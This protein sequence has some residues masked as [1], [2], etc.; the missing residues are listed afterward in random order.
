MAGSIVGHVL[1]VETEVMAQLVDDRVAD[2]A[3]DLPA[4]RAGAQDRPSVDE[5][6][7]GHGRLIEAVALRQGDAL[8]EA[9]QLLVRL[10]AEGLQVFRIGL[11]L[12]H[13][14]HVLQQLGE[15]LGQ[16]FQGLLDQSLELLG[17][18]AHGA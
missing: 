15:F 5:D 14:G 18:D 4:V 13:H 3:D 11:F 7:V 9:E 17:G 6:P 10:H 2:L 1:F 16:P 12:H 8:V